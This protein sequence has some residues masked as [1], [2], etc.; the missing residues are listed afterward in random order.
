L[1]LGVITRA[2]HTD[3]QA[4]L[5]TTQQAPPAHKQQPGMSARLLL[6]HRTSSPAAVVSARAEKLHRH[7]RI[8][9]AS[10]DHIG[11]SNLLVGSVNE[12]LFSRT[13]ANCRDAGPS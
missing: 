7:L 2:E 11:Q 4:H 12:A 13:E 6:T 1:A 8:H 10:F 5:C 3:E 9:F